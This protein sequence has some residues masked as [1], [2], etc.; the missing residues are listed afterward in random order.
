MNPGVRATAGH[1]RPKSVQARVI[2]EAAEEMCKI[3]ESWME[4]EQENE[5]SQ[6]E[7]ER[8]NS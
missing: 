1:G 5:K 3:R 7:T 6:S 8:W 4:R 2:V